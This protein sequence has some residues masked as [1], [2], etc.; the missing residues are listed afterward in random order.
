MPLSCKFATQTEGSIRITLG[1]PLYLLRG[2]A[3]S[4]FSGPPNL[5][6]FLPLSRSISASRPSFTKKAVSRIPVSLPAFSSKPS[7]ILSVVS[8]KIHSQS[9]FYWACF[10]MHNKN[11]SVKKFLAS[12]SIGKLYRFLSQQPSF[13]KGRGK[14]NLLGSHQISCF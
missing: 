14:K 3:S 4:F 12:L 6:S 10:S 1:V 2:K 13:P 8:I 9:L 7:S 5:A 11:A